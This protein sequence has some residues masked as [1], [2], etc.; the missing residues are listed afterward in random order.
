MVSDHDSH[1]SC[2]CHWSLAFEDYAAENAYHLHVQLQL[3]ILV[4]LLLFFLYYW[5][6][7]F[8]AWVRISALEFVAIINFD[9]YLP[10]WTNSTVLKLL[11]L[12]YRSLVT[13]S[14]KPS[15]A[16]P[17]YWYIGI[18]MYLRC[19]VLVCSWHH[20]G[21]VWEAIRIAIMVHILQ[22]IIKLTSFSLCADGRKL[23]HKVR[24]PQVFSTLWQ[25]FL[26]KVE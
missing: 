1:T 18:R 21:F 8:Q 25:F 9:T 7:V 16:M 23:R 24:F 4:G 11:I 6:T 20:S 5:V 17:W 19:L 13:L 14:F 3:Q 10:R 12:C 2:L 26:E 15:F 22:Y